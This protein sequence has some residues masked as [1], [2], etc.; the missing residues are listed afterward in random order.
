MQMFTVVLPERREVVVSRRL[1]Q[2]RTS[3]SASVEFAQ[4][5]SEVG[6][7]TDTLASDARARTLVLVSACQ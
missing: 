7:L 6:V 1:Q 5:L 4:W 2:F 3:C